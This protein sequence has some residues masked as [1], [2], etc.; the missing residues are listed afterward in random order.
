MDF[1]T[2]ENARGGKEV[3]M[4]IR[5]NKTD[6]E[7]GKDAWLVLVKKEPAE[8]GLIQPYKAVQQHFN[9]TQIRTTLGIYKACFIAKDTQPDLHFAVVNYP[10]FKTF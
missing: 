3:Q 5:Q 10:L 8:T 1:I 4:N 7:E 2:W 6:T 9:C